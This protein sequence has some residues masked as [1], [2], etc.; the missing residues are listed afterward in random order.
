MY[1]A[2]EWLRLG[3][4]LGSLHL[5]RVYIPS[6]YSYICLNCFLFEDNV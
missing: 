1:E 2:M 3:L 6:S 4:G 5:Q